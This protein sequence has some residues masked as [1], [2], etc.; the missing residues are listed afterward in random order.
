MNA[1]SVTIDGAGNP[2]GTGLSREFYDILAAAF[3]LGSVV[4][5]SAPAAQ[6]QIADLANAFGQAVV[7]HVTTNAEVLVASGIAVTTTGNASTQSGFTTATGTG[8]VS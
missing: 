2:S 8:T 6:Q 4:P 3:G 5:P 7:A 1:G